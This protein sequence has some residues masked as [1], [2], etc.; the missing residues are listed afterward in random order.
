MLREE[1]SL[2]T[3]LR[4]THSEEADSPL[5]LGLPHYDGHVRAVAVDDVALGIGCHQHVLAAPRLPELQA[6]VETSADAAL[7]R[8]RRREAHGG[9][10]FRLPSEEV[11][12]SRNPNVPLGPGNIRRRH[13][14]KNVIR[15]GALD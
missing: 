14:S 7:R 8:R 10:S 5:L 13:C 6:G 11:Q 1:F 12:K 9:K 3:E 15:K 4:L 2:L